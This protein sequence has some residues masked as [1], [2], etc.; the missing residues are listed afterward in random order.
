MRTTATFSLPVTS[1]PSPPPCPLTSAEGECPRRYS[2]GSSKRLPS[3][4]VT[5]SRRE[6]L[7]RRISVGVCCML[8][9][10]TRPAPAPRRAGSEDVTAQVFVARQLGQVAID[11]AGVDRQGGAGLVGRLE[12]NVLE[13]ALH[14]GVQPPRADI[15]GVLV[16]VVGDFR[17]AANAVVGEDQLHEIGRAHV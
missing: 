8:L 5:A 6:A 7:R 3:S 15:L 14:D 13:Q 17:D 12:G 11:V 9:R 2:N 1:M 10:R 16:H 4:N